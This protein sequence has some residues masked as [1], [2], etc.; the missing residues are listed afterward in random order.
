VR[1]ALSAARL[2]RHE[3]LGNEKTRS[4]PMQAKPPLQTRRQIT[5]HRASSSAF[6]SEGERWLGG[7][8]EEFVATGRELCS[9]R[10]ELPP[11][12]SCFVRGEQEIACL[13]SHSSKTT[14]WRERRGRLRVLMRSP[15]GDFYPFAPRSGFR[16]SKRSQCDASDA[17]AIL[18]AERAI[19]KDG[20][21]PRPWRAAAY[22]FRL[23][24]ATM[25]NSNRRHSIAPL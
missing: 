2:K 18:G 11:P 22:P 16:R 1:L 10:A 21:V 13:S 14:R 5:R 19:T 7:P 15:L 3:R 24:P 12:R 4:R 20:L 8:G 6:L 23:L 9:M 17:P 25:A